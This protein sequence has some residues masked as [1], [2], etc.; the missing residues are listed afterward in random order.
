MRLIIIGGVAAGSK[1]AAKARRQNPQLEIIIYQDEAELSYSACGMPYVIG[2]V[3]KNPRSLIVRT[4]DEFAKDG[5]QVFTRHRVMQ[6]DKI[7]KQLTVKNLQTDTEATVSFDRVILATGAK[8]IIPTVVG[9]DLQG[10]VTLRNYRDLQGLQTLLNSQQPKQAVIIGAGYIG[11]ELAEAF[12]NRAI[13]TTLLEKSPQ[14]LPKFDAE[15]ATLVHQYVVDKHVELIVGDG[16]VKL[17]G[18][19]GWVCAV[20]SET[21]K[22]LAADLVVVAIGI[23]PNTALAQD[24]GIALGTTGAIAVNAKM[25]TNAEG[26]FA[27]GDC[28]ET[29]DR[30]TGKPIWMPLGDISA[31]QGR[32]AGANA[33]G[34]DAHFSGVFGTAIFKTFALQVGCT[35]LSEKSARDC[36][37]APVSVLVT[38]TDKARYYPDSQ[39]LTLKLIAD[40]QNGRVLGAQAV[41]FGGVDKMI[42]IIATALLGK[43]SCADLENADLAYSPPFSPVLSPVI[44]AA[45]ALNKKID[46]LCF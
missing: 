31:L 20:E 32:V 3:I 4:A 44:V 40:K 19:Q 22:R 24:S 27:A 11:L 37:F 41:G 33:A 25:E 42:D 28:C 13:K 46:T 16:L 38:K 35:G 18:E 43:L 26:I 7:R 15:I 45:G 9:I 6:I 39:S 1:A 23:R 29:V 14:I 5:I 36:G 10:V 30:I 34:G 21:G 12:Q 17:H 2:G 8:P